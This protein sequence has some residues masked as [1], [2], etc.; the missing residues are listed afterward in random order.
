MYRL[1]EVANVLL[2][3]LAFLVWASYLTFVVD[4]AT[5]GT[6][7]SAQGNELEIFPWPHCREPRLPASATE[8]S[9]ARN[10]ILAAAAKD[11]KVI[12]CP[13][14]WGYYPYLEGQCGRL[15]LGHRECNEWIGTVFE[16]HGPIAC[17]WSACPK[18]KEGCVP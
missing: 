13:N 18:G 14:P 6:Q 9:A 1:R 17:G 7:C 16:A 4:V 15:G 5:T 11:P 10:T 12:L 3:V 2:G 8:M